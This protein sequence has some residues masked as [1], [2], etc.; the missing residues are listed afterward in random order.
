M[1][2][3]KNDDYKDPYLD[4]LDKF[5]IYVGT[6]EGTS[7]RPMIRSGIDSIVLKKKDRELRKYDC[8]L[9]KRRS[10]NKYVL[11]RIIKIKKDGSLIIC[12]DNLFQK[13]YDITQDDILAILDGF[14]RKEKYIPITAFWYRVYYHLRVFFRPL[15]RIKYYLLKPLRF[16]KHKLFK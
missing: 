11:H 13:E 9:Y 7:M 12:G 15:R 16:I 1:E 3:L 4:A 8:V 10:T 14:Y 6:T 2:S 5:G